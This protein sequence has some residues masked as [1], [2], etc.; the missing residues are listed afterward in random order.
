MTS[1]VPSTVRS[2]TPRGSAPRIVPFAA[3]LAMAA[4]L[5]PRE[6]RANV[7]TMEVW[8]EVGVRVIPV[9]RL[10]VTFTQN[11]RFST[12]YGLRRV[13]PEL[14]VDYRVFG[15][16][17]V[18]AGYRY[19]WRT[20]SLDEV[21]EGHRLH[22][23]VTVQLKPARHL[24]VELRSRVQ[25]RSVGQY[26][27]GYSYDDTR[28]MWRNRANVEWTFRAPFTVNAFVEH[29]ARIDD[30]VRHDRFRVG[31]GLSAD[32]AHW[33]FHLYYLRDMPDF[34]DSPDVNMVGLSARLELDLAHR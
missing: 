34:I 13:I 16:L 11:T 1:P 20:N 29:W 22:A 9:R 33:R 12:L 3:A 32:V 21:E 19:L 14:E 30:T 24:D 25:W 4:S 31:A 8:T 2:A 15:P 18:G 28:D 5:A 7:E 6:A 26:V 10:R 27:S 23:D 17:R